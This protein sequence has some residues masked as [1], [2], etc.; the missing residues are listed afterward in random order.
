MPTT[1]ARSSSRSPARPRAREAGT[2]RQIEVPRGARA[3]ST[4]SRIDYADAFLVDVADPRARTGEQWARAIVGGAPSALRARLWLA[5]TALG[6]R[7]GPPWSDRHVLGWEVRRSTP[8]LAL[9]GARSRI[10]MPAE[11]LVRRE[12]ETL[13]FATFVQKRNPLARAA[14]ASIDSVH[15]PVVRHVLREA[16]R[17]SAP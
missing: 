10:G 9:L 7:L 17:R 8:D 12:G 2:V 11:L 3:L 1:A 16:A 6:L 13:L 4:L 14:W 5:W 15:R